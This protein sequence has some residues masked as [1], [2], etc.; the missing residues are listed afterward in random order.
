MK[1]LYDWRAIVTDATF[2]S[3][4]CNVSSFSHLRCFH[5]CRPNNVVAYYNDGIRLVSRDAIRQQ[6]SDIFSELPQ[7]ALDS[8]I[9]HLNNDPGTQEV[10]VGVDCQFLLQHCGHYCVYGS[11]YLTGLAARIHATDNQDYRQRLKLIGRP[12]V[13]ILDVPFDQL[14][15]PDAAELINELH[16]V[17]NS[18]YDRIIMPDMLLDFGISFNHAVPPE[19]IVGHSHPESIWDPFLREEYVYFS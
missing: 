2:L 14:P 11:E 16:R 13:I 12:T 5:L 7:D 19:W 3:S 6:F 8:A 10:F 15:P 18:D 4:I 17:A 1:A 9:S